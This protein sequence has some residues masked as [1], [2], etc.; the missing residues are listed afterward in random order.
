MKM[1]AG[2][3]QPSEGRL[4][5]GEEEVYFRDTTDARKHGIGIIHQELSLFPNLPVYQNIFMARKKKKGVS[6]DNQYH[7]E[8]A[9]EKN[10]I[11]MIIEGKGGHIGGDMSVLDILVELYFEQMIREF[12]KFGSKFIGHPNN[13]LPG[14]EMNSGSLGHGLPISVGMALAAKLDGGCYGPGRPDAAL[15]SL[16]MARDPRKGK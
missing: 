14:I 16:W 6:I 1:I 4:F 2:I 8:K 9:A 7:R 11:D 10:V 13:K 15:G 3:E 5:M 12:S